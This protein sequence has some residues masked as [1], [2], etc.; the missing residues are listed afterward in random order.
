MAAQVIIREYADLAVTYGKVVQAPAEPGLADQTIATIVTTSVASA[1]FGANT[2]VIAISTPAAEAV[3]CA[4][5]A[6][7]GAT[8]TASA[9]TFLLPGN[10]VFFFGVRPGD[11]VALFELA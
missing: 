1:A 6:T 2:R 9:T 8:P 10:S 11:K 7:P 4:F 3:T 5:S